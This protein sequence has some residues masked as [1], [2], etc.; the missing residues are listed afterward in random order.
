MA[1][2]CVI[3]SRNEFYYTK[4]VVNTNI[5]M[6]SHSQ[7]LIKISVSVVRRHVF[8]SDVATFQKQTWKIT[9]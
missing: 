2:L 3:L 6:Y 7:K 4:R 5:L 8:I 1:K 9:R